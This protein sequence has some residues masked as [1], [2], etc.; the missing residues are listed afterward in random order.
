MTCSHLMVAYL[1]V[2]NDDKP[3]NIAL[4]LSVPSVCLAPVI[5][6]LWATFCFQNHA[7][8]TFVSVLRFGTTRFTANHSVSCICTFCVTEFIDSKLLITWQ[9]WNFSNTV[10]TEIKRIAQVQ[11]WAANGA[12]CNSN[13][14]SIY[15]KL[16]VS[17]NCIWI[18]IQE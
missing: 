3:S 9:W 5:V 4:T 17:C 8:M 11:C 15:C 16:L 12:C 2:L 1:I 10:L 14:D 13:A 7:V 6:M 18:L